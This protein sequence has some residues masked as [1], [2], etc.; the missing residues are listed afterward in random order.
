MRSRWIPVFALALAVPAFADNY[1]LDPV[2]CSATFKA[3]HLGVSRVRG[4][5]NDVSGKASFDEKD[6]AK[7]SIEVQIKAESVDTGNAD[8]DKH[9]RSPDFFNAKQ[10]TTLSFK[11]TK[12]EKSDKGYQITGDLTIHGV[13]K[14]ITVPFEIV[15]KGKGMKGEERIGG[16][17]TFTIKRSDYGMNFMVGPVGDEIEISVSVEGI[18]E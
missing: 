15:G 14:A 3:L 6:A 2:H 8:R 10:F 18:K 5:F 4:R 11:S 13:T 17:T 7:S 16:E 1:S 9:L 12:V